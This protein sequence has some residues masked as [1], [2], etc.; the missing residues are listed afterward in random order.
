M[1][2][3][4][5][6]RIDCWVLSSRQAAGEGGWEGIGVDGRKEGGKGRK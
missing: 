1:I 5:W 6:L 4:V 3:Y 2:L